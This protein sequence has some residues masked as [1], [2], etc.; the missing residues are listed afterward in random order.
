MR[1]P[2]TVLGVA[3]HASADEVKA[4]FRRLAREHH[5][6]RNPQDSQ[7]EQRFREINEAYQLLSDP[8]RRARF[9]ANGSDRPGPSPGA[10][11]GFGGFEDLLSELFGGLGRRPTSRGDMRLVVAVSFR[12]AA[13][14]CTKSLSY[15]RIELCGDCEGSGAKTGSGYH[16]CRG[17]GG[18][19][20]IAASMGTWFAV[21]TEQ[22]CPQCGGRGRLAKEPCFGCRGRGL[23]TEKRTIDVKL[24]PGIEGGAALPVAGGGSRLAPGA[25]AGDLELVV[26]VDPDAQF[27]RE[28][29]DVVSEVP[30]TFAQATLGAEVTVETL[31]GP[32]LAR[33]P[34]GSKPGDELKLKG[35]G[36][37]HRFRSG[38]GHHRARLRLTVPK[39]VSPRARE[40]LQQFD[41]ACGE[42][43]DGLFERLRGFF[44]G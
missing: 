8:T 37:P 39:V 2:Y 6:D 30:V 32:Q 17:C 23:A 16:T 12:E 22:L 10:G 15:E 35:M 36:V 29:D 5:P 34:P 41:A 38:A 43:D 24:P 14:G 20:R 9:D 7:A 21:R 18:A 11:P 4:A 28:G 31:H 25:P 33:V 13:L 42:G 26:Q 1:D 19:G 27:A 40:L 44:Q 3:R